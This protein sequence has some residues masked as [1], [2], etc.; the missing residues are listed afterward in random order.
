[1]SRRAGASGL[2]PGVPFGVIDQRHDDRRAPPKCTMACDRLGE[3]M[4]KA[5]A[6]ACPTESI[7]SR[8]FDDLRAPGSY[9]RLEDH[10]H[11]HTASR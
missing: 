9:P 5:C 2:H 10:D 1:M 8:P 6:K 3:G 7:R 11:A 4:E